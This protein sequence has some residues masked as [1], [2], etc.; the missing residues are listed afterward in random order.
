MAKENTDY[1]GMGCTAVIAI[2]IENVLH[3][4]HVGDARCYICNQEGIQQLGYDHSY[5]AEAVKEGQM[6]REEARTSNLKNEINEDG[7]ACICT[8]E[9]EIGEE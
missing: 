7:G 3:T 4:S 2:L 5:I 1:T 6:T 9:G 8:A